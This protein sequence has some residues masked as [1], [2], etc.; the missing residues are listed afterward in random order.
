MEVDV[1][2]SCTHLGRKLKR[3][4]ELIPIRVGGNIPFPS[5]IVDVAPILVATCTQFIFER[6]DAAYC[7]D[8]P[9]GAPLG[10][11]FGWVICFECPLLDRKSV[12]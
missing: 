10:R 7:R 9:P 5:K 1:E 12:V 3:N 4:G 6:I 11:I 8:V 2:F